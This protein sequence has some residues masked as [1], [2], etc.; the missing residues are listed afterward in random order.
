MFFYFTVH[1]ILGLL[2]GCS[3]KIMKDS[4][5]STADYPLWLK[6]STWANISPILCGICAFLAIPTTFFNWGL[7]YTFY[8]VFEL[9]L[10]VMITA[11]VP[12]S[13]RILMLAIGPV[14]SIII[15]GALW[16]FWYI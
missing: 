15:M 8:T 16:G 9:I 3:V 2:V 12:T 6:N 13:I 5:Y 7:T 4:E 14:I 11:L 1:V 10:G